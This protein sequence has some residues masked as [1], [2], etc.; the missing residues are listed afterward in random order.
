MLSNSTIAKIKRSLCCSRSASNRTKS[1]PGSPHKDAGCSQD[2]LSRAKS[3]EYELSLATGLL[4]FHLRDQGLIQLHRTRVG[5]P[6]LF[7]LFLKSRFEVVTVAT[8]ND[9]ELFQQE[10]ATDR[11][12][13]GERYRRQ[14]PE[15]ATKKRDPP[16]S[17]MATLAAG[18]TKRMSRGTRSRF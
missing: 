9:P 16:Q 2:A 5:K 15:K 13:I 1:H 10:V 7:G 6:L 4:H 17:I 8:P 11:N 14:R 18:V 3:V 12:K